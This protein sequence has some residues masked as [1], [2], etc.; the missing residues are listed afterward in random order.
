MAV[1][2]TRKCVGLSI[3]VWVLTSTAARPVDAQ[4]R[5]T[6][7]PG[8]GT[9]ESLQGIVEIR[10]QSDRLWRP[11]ALG[12]TVCPGDGIRVGEYGRA[13]LAF[14]ETNEVL[15]LDQ[16]TTIRLPAVAGQERPLLNLIMGVAQFFSNHPKSFN[17]QT[18]FMNAGVEG[19]EFVV[20]VT[21]GET[22]LAVFSGRVRAEN[23][24]GAVV[25]SGDRAVTAGPGT[26]PVPQIPVRP[27]DA[28]RWAI[29]YPPVLADLANG[30]GQPPSSDLPEAVRAAIDLY[31]QNRIA[32][33]IKRL[34]VAPGAEA[35]PRVLVYRAGLLLQVGR[36]DEAS[37]DLKRVLASNPNWSGALALRAITAVAQNDR[38]GALSDANRAVALDPGSDTALIA[39]SYALQ[40]SFRL[41]EARAAV[42]AALERHPENA[43]AWA[44]LAELWLSLGYRQRALEA[45]HRAAEIAPDLGRTQLVLGFAQLAEMDTTAAEA[46]FRKAI[47]T[48]NSDPR[49]RLGLGLARIRRNDLIGGREQLEIAAGLDPSNSLVRSY[50]GKAYFEERRPVPAGMALAEARALDPLD[51]TAP[52]YSAILNQAMNRPV[53]A[54]TDLQQAIDLNGNRAVY[55]SS[56]LL[57]EDLA[58]RQASLGRIY[59]DLGFEQQA[60]TEAA[61]SL[62]L[63]PA[64][65]SAHRFLSDIYQDRPRHELARASELLQSQLLQ[66]LG[67]DPIQPRSAIANLNIL[68]GFGPTEVSFN[69][70]GPLFA[71]EGLRFTGSAV[72][73]SNGTFGDEAVVSGLIGRFAFSAGQFHYESDGY[74]SNSDVEH[75]IYNFFAQAEL[76]DE[77]SVQAEYRHRET[78]Q[79]DLTQDF[80]PKD[81]NRSDRTSLDQ[82]TI[83]LGLH[84]EPSPDIDVIASVIKIDESSRIQSKIQSTDESILPQAPNELTTINNINSLKTN[85]YD[86]QLQLMYHNPHFDVISGGGFSKV[87]VD[88]INL[89]DI[90]NSVSSLHVPYAK[91]SNLFNANAYTYVNVMSPENVIWTAGFSIDQRKS[92]LIPIDEIRAN[93]KIG[94]QWN[95]TDRI[96]L[97]G[98]IF[99]TGQRPLI[100]AQTP[101]P[102]QVAGFNQFFD[103]PE[104]T[105]ATRYAAGLDINLLKGVY[106]GMEYSRRRLRIPISQEPIGKPPIFSNQEE[107]LFQAYLNWTPDPRWVFGAE[108]RYETIKN[109]P[110]APFGPVVG[111]TM[112]ERNVKTLEFPFTMKYFDPNGFFAQIGTTFVRQEV[113]PTGTTTRDNFL[114]LDAAIGYRLPNRHAIISLEARNL[115]GEDFIYRD[116]GYITYIQSLANPRYIPAR[117]V[118][119]R[120]TVSF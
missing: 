32:E 19:T 103:D 88:R 12:E 30:S 82:D 45:A 116:E 53:E 41:E 74:R 107:R 13:G 96:R 8:T 10:R 77:L 71:R 60:T 52:F 28:V 73:G 37:D 34:T 108:L 11:A 98:A 31:R 23:Q 16:N 22:Y 36:L 48:D 25:V 26:A 70:F 68:S 55:R 57:D 35:D 46:T 47:Q 56:L 5:V 69:E 7:A 119:G 109:S 62:S 105:E 104:A 120:I 40:A 115:L 39:Q 6:C 117:T 97:R 3:L 67:S 64:N 102:T 91:R 110:F 76:T 106:T 14:S 38:E 86:A 17:V 24:F 49:S 113:H 99:R 112:E 54:L 29:Y 114:V 72:L 20:R 2:A 43:L 9:I 4:D 84:Y 15:R 78:N 66:P 42:S 95:V 79:G 59:Q 90:F 65:H 81:S 87:D 92:Q 61:K 1:R 118:L 21:S 93:P 27:R 58:V 83:R 44:R 63:D 33:A 18:P 100:A 51:P 50:L 111:A 89:I 85:G 80:L 75:D 101:E 94:V